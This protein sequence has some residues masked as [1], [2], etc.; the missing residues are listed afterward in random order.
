[1]LLLIKKFLSYSSML[2]GLMEIANGTGDSK[3][4]QKVKGKLE[5]HR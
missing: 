2:H 4:Q 3:G 5:Q 1:M